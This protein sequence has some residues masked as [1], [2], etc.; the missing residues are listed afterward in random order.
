MR[1]HGTFAPKAPRERIAIYV[2]TSPEHRLDNKYTSLAA[3]RDACAE[4]IAAGAADRWVLVE[5]KEHP[6]HGGTDTERPMLQQLRADIAAG[7]VDV[8]LEVVAEVAR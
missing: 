4:Y 1:N 8:V 6:G 2:R 5:R 7:Q 3:Q